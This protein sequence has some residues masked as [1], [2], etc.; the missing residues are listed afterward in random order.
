MPDDRDVRRGAGR[1]EVLA[2]GARRV[3]VAAGSLAE[4]RK[5]GLLR[6]EGKTHVVKDGETV[7]LLGTNGNGK[8]TLIKCIMG[9]IQP[10]SGQIALDPNTQ[11]MVQGDIRAQT[12]RVMDNLAAVLEDAINVLRKRP[13]SRAG[14]EAHDQDVLAVRL[15]DAGFGKADVEAI[16]GLQ[17]GGEPLDGA[18]LLGPEHAERRMMRRSRLRTMRSRSRR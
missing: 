7:T 1:V 6:M 16:H 12:E 13:R 4:A 9:L 11:Q 17:V 5:R 2:R 10:T 18:G 14:R 8:S 15:L 3:I